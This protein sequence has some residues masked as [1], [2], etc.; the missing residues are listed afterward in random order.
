[1]AKTKSE[2]EDFN[3]DEFD[4]LLAALNEDDLDKINDLVDPEV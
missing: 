1:M 4:S 2:N 3:M